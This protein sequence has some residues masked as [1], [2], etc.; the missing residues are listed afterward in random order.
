[1]F[2]QS[3]RRKSDPRAAAGILARAALK[4]FEIRDEPDRLRNVYFTN[5]IRLLEM[6]KYDALRER[7]PQGILERREITD[8][9]LAIADSEPGL[10]ALDELLRAAHKKYYPKLDKKHL[11]DHLRTVLEQIQHQ[12]PRS[13]NAVELEKIQL[14]LAQLQ[15]TTP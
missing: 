5:L 13:I 9:D 3:A 15:K 6:Y 11:V 1:M 7:N 4:R 12:G 10:E 8:I 2:I 14:F